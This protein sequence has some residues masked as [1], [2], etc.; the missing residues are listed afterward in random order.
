MQDLSLYLFF[1]FLTLFVIVLTLFC[2]SYFFCQPID[3]ALLFPMCLLLPDYEGCMSKASTKS[4]LC[5]ALA[6]KW[7]NK[8]QT[9][10]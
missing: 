10:H 3:Y 6:P 2:S 5:P 8:E 4:R 7:C 1:S 9:P